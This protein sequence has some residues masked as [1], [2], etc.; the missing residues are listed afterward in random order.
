MKLRG[1]RLELSEI[2]AVLKSNALVGDIVLQ[3]HTNANEDQ[4]LVAYIVATC[5]D[6][7]TRGEL[8][9][10]TIIWGSWASG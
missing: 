7:L 3:K 6:M 10:T 5:S 4:F 2:E 1:Q 8:E 9:G